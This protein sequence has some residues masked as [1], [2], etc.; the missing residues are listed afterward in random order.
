MPS[1]RPLLVSV[2]ARAVR[3]PAVAVRTTTRAARARAARAL[4]LAVALGAACASAPPAV[5]TALPDDA[6]ALADA[7]ERDRE[8][9]LDWLAAPPAAGRADESDDGAPATPVRA[10]SDD[11]LRALAL[12]MPALQAALAQREAAARAGA[13]P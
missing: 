1:P 12:R 10:P 3:V 6:D 4:A 7:L 5:D 13:Q 2:R 9:V 11:E 8:R